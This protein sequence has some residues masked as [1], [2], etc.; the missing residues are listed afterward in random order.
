MTNSPENSSLIDNTLNIRIFI[1]WLYLSVGSW[2][3]VGACFGVNK[4]VV[5]HMAHDEDYEPQSAE[6]RRRL[7]LQEYAPAPVCVSCGS[8][9]AGNCNP[10]RQ[11]VDISAVPLSERK[12][13]LSEAMERMMK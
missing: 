6:L 10:G 4:G 9:H 13:L 12:Y 7:G 8:V 3:V 1:V 5:W 2:D 11:M